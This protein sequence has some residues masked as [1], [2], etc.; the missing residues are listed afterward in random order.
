M[1][2]LLARQIKRHLGEESLSDERLKL[3]FESIAS[4]YADNEKENKLLENALAHSTQE[5]EKAN[6][7]LLKQKDSLLSIRKKALD[8]A[9]NMILITDK[10]G[11]IEYANNLFYSF[12]GFTESDVLWKNTRTLGTHMNSDE[13]Y[14]NLWDTIGSGKV[15]DGVL[16]NKKRNGSIYP[17]EM[18]VTPIFEGDTITHFV[19][20][21]KDITERLDKEAQLKATMEKALEASKMKSEFLSTMSH[22]IRT[23]MNGIIGMTEILLGT[24]LDKEQTEFA[25]IIRESSDSLLAI[26]NDILDF[27][28]MEAGKMTIEEVDFDLKDTCKGVIRLLE[29]KAKEKGLE[30]I[31][32][33]D[34]SLPIYVK[35]DPV[36][37]RQIILNLVGNAIKFTEKGFVK[38]KLEPVLAIK[39]GFIVRFVIEDSGIGISK[40]TQKKL[41]QSFTQADGST[42]RRYGGTGLGLA[43][44]KKLIAL[45]DGDIGV[46]SEGGQGSKFWFEIPL[47][48]SQR[49]FQTEEAA[50]GGT[51]VTT[52]ASNGKRLLLAE[53]NIVN[54]KVAVVQL[55]KL[56]YAVD[57]AENGQKAVEL[58]LANGNYEL[59]LMDCQMPTLDGFEA[60]RELRK[61]GFD[62]PIIAMTAN[63]MQGDRER[64]IAAGMDDYVTK[65]INTNLLSQTLEKYIKTDNVQNSTDDN[66]KEKPVYFLNRDRLN[67]FFGDD[68]ET[69]KEFLAIYVHSTTELIDNLHAAS[70]EDNF[71]A[72]FGLGHNLK[73]S[74]ANAGAERLSAI[75][76]T[77][78]MAAKAKDADKI[79]ESMQEIEIIFDLIKEEIEGF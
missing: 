68:L 36:R 8:A 77:I 32:D 61:Q 11:T 76:A 24:E 51:S 43:I 10:D 13:F 78:E 45:M 73:G 64:C 72:L 62:K 28:K 60:T 4:S 71:D 49:N 58:A 54:Q 47:K 46:V 63:A 31:M 35:T 14:K 79:A 6:A 30:L 15:W 66:K 27:S 23:P 18:T 33:M 44:C 21:K 34:A 52:P 59:I 17:E 50:K 29:S 9:G 75:G 55:N 12:T 19:A 74:S 38:I 3:F 48:I 70:N 65:P 42:T 25:K 53:D 67:D 22:E 56:G 41:F 40:E 20:V 5:L 69:L 16:Y 37:V 7:T 26:L 1:H 39:D 2:R 57:V